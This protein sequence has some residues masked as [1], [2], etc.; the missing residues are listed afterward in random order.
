MN[1]EFRSVQSVESSPNRLRP[2]TR[3]KRLMGAAAVVIAAF[4]VTKGAEMIFGRDLH[5]EGEQAVPVQS[6]DTV[7]DIITENV[8]GIENVETDEVVNY[9]LDNPANAEVFEDGAN[10]YPSEQVIVPDEVS[11]S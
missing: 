5:V 9:V 1:K 4:G 3:A 6:G 10:V 2:T 11:Y 8:D 7:W